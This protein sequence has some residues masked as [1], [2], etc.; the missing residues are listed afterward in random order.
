M[1]MNIKNFKLVNSPAKQNSPDNQKLL[2]DAPSG[3]L[4]LESE[5][6]VDWYIA[7]K[8]FA[9]DTV[10][11]QYDSSGVIVAVVD[12]PLPQRGNT[13]AASA[14]WPVNCS[15]AEMS[16]EDYPAITPDGTWKYDAE[17]QTVYQDTDLIADNSL[18]RNTRLRGQYA[19]T[20]ALNIATLQAGI[21]SD[22]SV[23][24]DSDALTAWQGYLC[25][26][27]AMTTDDLQQSPAEFPTAPV[28]IF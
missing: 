22:R 19:A 27:R 14:L 26:L 28:S 25:D 10:K 17:A 1:N 16:V 8:L 15:V 4:F 12:K 18:A 2:G 7:Q 13:Y 3:A 11:I 20:A 24:G 21:A 6:G 9:D 23:E 5:D